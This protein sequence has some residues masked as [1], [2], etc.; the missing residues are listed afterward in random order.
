MALSNHTGKKLTS[1]NDSNKSETPDR[2]RLKNLTGNA[3]DG[4]YH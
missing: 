4:G 3:I 2:L 1:I